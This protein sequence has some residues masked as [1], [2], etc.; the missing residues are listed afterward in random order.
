MEAALGVPVLRHRSKKPAG[1]TPEIE[2]L[3]GCS[4]DKAVMVGDRYLTDVVFGTLNGM[5]TVRVAPFDTSG[6][7]F[8]VRAARWLEGALVAAYR[9]AGVAAPAQE[10]LGGQAAA[11]E[12]GGFVRQLRG[13][14]SDADDE[15]GG[16][17][18]RGG[19]AADG[20]GGGW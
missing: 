11:F 10:L 9:R 2:A 8:A 7:S 6:E 14:G 16:W 5:L 4:P 19:A 17:G 18:S 3:L 13:A 20:A 1:G 12:A 15:G